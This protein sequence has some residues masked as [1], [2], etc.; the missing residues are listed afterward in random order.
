MPY[1]VKAV[2]DLAGLSVRALHHYDAIGLLRPA[3]A[4]PAGYRLYGPR[5]LERL[6]QVMF[7]RELGFA[8]KDIKRILDS[9]GFD[10]RQALLQHRELLLQRRDR[11]D[12]LLRSVDRTLSSM[13]GG[14]EMDPKDMFG[15]FDPKQYEEEAKERWGKSKEYQQ[16]AERT[17]KYTKDD[18]TR[19]LGE[20]RDVT[21]A[22]GEKMAAGLAP[23]HPEVQELIRRHHQHIDRYFYTC[24]TQVYRGLGEMYAADERFAANYERVRPGL[25]RFMKEAMHAYCDKLEGR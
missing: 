3:S 6:Q 23:A 4:S 17:K 8:L 11:L 12:R 1:T 24:S 22:L 19:I 25:A 7:F 14:I 2:A 13:G 18:W 5:D 20:S 16:S 15:G 9:P 21:T 10:P